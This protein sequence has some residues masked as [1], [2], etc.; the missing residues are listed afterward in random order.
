LA[1]ENRAD[2]NAKQVKF[3]ERELK[4][5]AKFKKGNPG[6]SSGRSQEEHRWLPPKPLKREVI[7]RGDQKI[8]RSEVQER[9]R[10]PSKAVPKST[11]HQENK[12]WG[13]FQSGK[14]DKNRQ[15]KAIRRHEVRSGYPGHAKGEI[16]QGGKER[17][18]QG[19]DNLPSRFG[20]A[21]GMIRGRHFKN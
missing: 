10:I 15:S 18:Y 13:V 4:R 2:R 19:S 17:A 16:K 14:T 6:K 20:S 7:K 11:M 5:K 8:I 21:R 3:Q 9:R 12:G 1:P